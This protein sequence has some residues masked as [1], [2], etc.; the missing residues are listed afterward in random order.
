M[1]LRWKKRND[2]KH[3]SFFNSITLHISIEPNQEKNKKLSVI[4][5]A[6][7]SSSNQDKTS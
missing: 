5:I 3:L 6:Q 4:F 1:F 7:C 2:S